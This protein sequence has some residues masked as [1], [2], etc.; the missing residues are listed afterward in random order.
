MKDINK[1]NIFLTHQNSYGF[2][3]QQEWIYLFINKRLRNQRHMT[4]HG[5]INICKF[6]TSRF[7]IGGSGGMKAI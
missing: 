6:T 5:T 3:E 2:L 1:E 7:D 4:P